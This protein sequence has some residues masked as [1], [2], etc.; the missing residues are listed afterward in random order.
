MYPGI[1]VQM[2]TT[3]RPTD[4]MIEVAIASMEEA[5]LADGEPVP[6]G[7]PTLERAPMRL[8]ARRAAAPPSD[9]PAGHRPPHAAPDPVSR[10]ADMS[11]LDAKLAEI[12][13]QYDDVQAELAKP[14][15]VADPNADP[16][17]RA[18]AVAPGTGRRGVPAPD[19]DARGA[20]RRA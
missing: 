7:S 13:R 18:R 5:L 1:L 4:D 17:A 19:R 6:A 10:R 16:P 9:P 8:P 3:K 15:V 11:D 2:I 20:G 12:A 14:E